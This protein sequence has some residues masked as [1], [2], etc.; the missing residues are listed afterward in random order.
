MVSRLA[1]SLPAPSG[2]AAGALDH[3]LI[4]TPWN[5]LRLQSWTTDGRLVHEVRPEGALRPLEAFL[6]AG[7]IGVSPLIDRVTGLHV[8]GE[9]TFASTYSPSSDVS[10]IWMI[11]NDDMQQLDAPFQIEIRAGTDELLRVSRTIDITELVAY[12]VLRTGG[13]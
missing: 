6:E 8:M 10:R 5:P 13:G 9:T 7:V 3:G 2:L 12:R 11:S 1:S 4:Y